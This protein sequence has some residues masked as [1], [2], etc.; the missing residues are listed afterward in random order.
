MKTVGLLL[1]N[2]ASTDDLSP[3]DLLISLSPLTGLDTRPPE[4]ID[5]EQTY[6]LYTLTE[7]AD[8]LAMDWARAA[9]ATL[10]SSSWASLLTYKG[11]DL[12][13][14]VINRL[15]RG[16]FLDRARIYLGARRILETETPH[17]VIIYSSSNVDTLFAQAACLDAG[18]ESTI[19]RLPIAARRRISIPGPLQ[20]FACDIAAPALGHAFS[21]PRPPVR[22][23][24]VPHVV[25]IERGAMASQMVVNAFDVLQ[26]GRDVAITVVRFEP[27]HSAQEYPRARCVNWDDYQNLATLFRLLA[28]QTCVM[29]WHSAHT[30]WTNSVLSQVGSHI[31]RFLQQV[32]LPSIIHTLELMRRI[33]QVECPDLLAVVDETGLLGKAV[34]AQGRQ[35]DVPTLN[36]QHGVRTDSPWIEDQLFDRFAVFGPS[37]SEVF[38]KRGNA[39]TIFVPT[40]VPRYDRLFRREGIKSREQVAAELGLDLGRPII[41]FASQRAWGRMT[42]AVKR[43]TL[44]A[45]LRARRQTDAQLVVKLRH[46]QLDYVPP[47]AI[48]EPGWE[49]VKVTAEYN[50]YDLLNASD[51]VVT[52]YSTVGMEAVALGKPLL[53][54]NLT[55]QPDLIPYVQEGVALGVYQSD[56]VGQALLHLLSTGRPNPDWA[57]H[58]QDF[59]RRHL[60]SDD[61][62]SAE[63]VARLMLEMIKR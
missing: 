23:T 29:A 19:F 51:V 62:H 21:T 9:Y 28:H 15:F 43:E 40:G 47:E 34:A 10:A 27:E 45:L 31:I 30:D 5:G 11:I 12:Q 14:L 56:H 60:T 46:G 48:R 49:H 1:G 3:V 39:P 7:Q 4:L 42:P 37:T 57:Q 25:F 59:I 63:R 55:G 13:P 33:I 61:G 44:L 16:F 6:A 32:A 22:G 36:I 26:T 41:A 24:D 50:L 35:L 8:D 17:R 18:I 2:I 58:R 53:I 38:V 52:A 54:I 20:T